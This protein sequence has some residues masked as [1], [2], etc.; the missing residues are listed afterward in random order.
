MVNLKSMA[1]KDREVCVEEHDAKTEQRRYA[2]NSRELPLSSS[3]SATCCG[4]FPWILPVV[5]SAPEGGRS[6]AA[7]EQFSGARGGPGPL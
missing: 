1:A 3:D 5:R 4:E 2:R 7:F 6:L